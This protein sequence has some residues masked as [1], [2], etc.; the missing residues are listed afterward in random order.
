MPTI[1]DEQREAS[2]QY[3]DHHPASVCA[4]GHTGDGEG[5]QHSSSGAFSS[6]HGAC[7][8]EGCSCLQFR[9]D[10][11]RIPYKQATGVK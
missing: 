11:F 7:V 2:R 6:G 1:T 5:S 10:R 3:K 8:V 9:W 4:C